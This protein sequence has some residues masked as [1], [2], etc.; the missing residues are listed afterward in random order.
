M[1]YDWSNV[2]TS[3]MC[4]AWIRQAAHWLTKE[5]TVIILSKTRLPPFIE[6]EMA[7]S[8][9]AAFR[10]MTHPGYID[11]TPGIPEE[12]IGMLRYKLFIMTQIT[13]PFLFIDAD[14]MI[15]GDLSPL[16]EVFDCK[17]P[18]A[19]IDHEVDIPRHTLGKPPFLN[20]GILLVNDPD[21]KVMHWEKLMAFARRNNFLF[22]FPGT[23][24]IVPGNDQ[25]LLYR[26]CDFLNYDYHHP[27]MG[28]E[29][30]TCSIKVTE[31][32]KEDGVW[33]SR[34]ENGP[35]RIFHYWW[36]YKPWQ[37]VK[38]PLFDEV[39]DDYMH[40]IHPFLEKG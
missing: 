33:K 19:G 18:M 14:A 32:V 30:N 34:S 6:R 25:A 24:V 23:N 28:I 5:D 2:D 37:D 16:K 9:T 20:S 4:V 36:T 22:R 15:V 8:K 27:A 21:M 11:S 12:F 40:N 17:L 13:F 38:C 26:Y 7:S 35:V 31:T 29:Y 10:H 3:A 1:N 39:K